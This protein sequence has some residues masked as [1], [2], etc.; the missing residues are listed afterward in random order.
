MIPEEKIKEIKKRLRNGYP[1]G[2]LINDL[3]KEGY[4]L[5][6]IREAIWPASLSNITENNDFPIWYLLSVG[7]FILGLALIAV[8][9][10]WLSEYGWFFIITG[11]AGIVLHFFLRVKKGHH[12]K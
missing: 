7:F 2:E 4:A 6:D 11:I 1:E 9:I 3:L 8:P 12:K 5:E 10:V